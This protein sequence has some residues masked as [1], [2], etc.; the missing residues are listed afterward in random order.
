MDLAISHPNYFILGVVLNLVNYQENPFGA[1]LT[2]PY[3]VNITKNLKNPRV[4]VNHNEVK[5]FVPSEKA[6]VRNF[7]KF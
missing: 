2:K 4:K 7:K 5:T 1:S 6:G 3:Q